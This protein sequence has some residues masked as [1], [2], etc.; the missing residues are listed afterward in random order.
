MAMPAPTQ[1]ETALA[2]RL[3]ALQQRVRAAA[4]GREVQLLA[5]SKTQPA[6]AVSVLAAVGQTAFGENYVQEAQDKIQALAGT[7]LCWHLIGHLQSNKCTVA[8]QLFDCIQGVDRAKLLPLLDAGRQ[9]SGRGPLD[10]LLQ[11]NIDDEASKSGCAPSAL[12]ALAEAA[13][14]FSQLRLRGIMSI[15]SPDPDMARRQRSFAALRSVFE[16]LRA[17]HPQIDT[18]S[19]GMSEDFELAIR[20]GAT[21][22]RVGS[23]LFGPRAVAN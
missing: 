10:I 6:E 5:V 13:A 3:Q 7:P 14:N 16:R 2:E 21:L 12:P 19:M 18:L 11:V 9:A 1:F 8:A 4:A 15:P 22:V 17:E 23:A 20:E